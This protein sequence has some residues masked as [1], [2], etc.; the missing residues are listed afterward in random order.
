MKI[1]LLK[2]KIFLFLILFLAFIFISNSNISYARSVSFSLKDGLAYTIKDNIDENKDDKEENPNIDIDNDEIKSDEDEEIVEKEQIVQNG[3]YMIVCAGN[4]EYVLDVEGVS[5]DNKANLHIWQRTKAP[6]QKFYITYEGEG[7]YKIASINSAKI[8]DVD[9]AS[10]KSEANIWQYENNET[11][12]QRFKI[13]NN[14]DGTYSFI[15]KCSGMAIDVSGGIYKNGRNVRQYYINNTNAQKFKLV[16]TELLGEDIVSIRKA[17]N[18]KMI[19]DVPNNSFEDGKALNLWEV[20]NTLAQRFEIHKV[21]ENKVRIR[22]ASSGGWLTEKGTKN[23]S[24]VV[25]L[26]N[27][28]SPITKA[29]TWKVEWNNG[30]TF[31]NME[32]GLYLD[33]NGNSND[34]GAK[35]QVWEKNNNQEAQR[36]LV[37]KENLISNGWYEISSLLGTTMDLDNSGSE[38]GTNIQMWQNNNQFNQK[39]RITYT[40]TGYLITTMYGLALDVENGSTENGANVRQ[41][42]DNG[43]SC[44]RWWPEI[45]DNGYIRFKNANSGKYLDVCNALSTNGANVQQYE[46][47]GTNAQLWKLTSTTFDEF[48]NAWGDD[49]HT[50]IVYLKTVIDRANR[51][52]S[53]TDWFI[54]VDIRRFRI[55]TLHRINGKWTVDGCFNATMG[56]LGSNGMSHTGL[57]DQ[58]GKM[59]TNWTVTHKNANCDGNLWFVCFIDHWLPNGY[60]DGQGFH[61]HYE[62][63]G[64]S[65]SSHGCPRLT[66]EHAKYLYDN[67][68]VGTRVHI[69]HEY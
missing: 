27:S 21:E 38:W 53:D 25:Q 37:N 51:I 49:F 64:Q 57:S 66:D 4:E 54:A 23:G 22:T 65:Y 13:I 42:E 16:K 10:K 60:D 68:P 56:Y 20:N 30:I 63:N 41:W 1:K 17:S 44:Q 9:S 34:N 52:G 15:A 8:I 48:T 14:S 36:F 61:N 32:S 69:W 50:D 31:K 43:T 6:N 45:A 46:G 67:V 40:D 58:S 7:Y 33:I 47:N 59:E 19:L 24:I 12:A 35:I 3:A 5:L 26:G 18:Y 28:S 2:R 29:N 62:L 55:T 39:F 11:E